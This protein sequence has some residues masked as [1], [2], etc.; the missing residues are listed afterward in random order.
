MLYQF[1]TANR[2]ELIKRCQ[3]KTARRSMPFMPPALVNHGVPLFLKQLV[4]VLHGEHLTTEREHSDTEPTPAHTDIGKAAALH[5]AEMLRLGHSIDQ[6]VHEYGDVCQTVTDLAVE[7]KVAISIDEFRTLNRCLD[8]AIADAVASYAEARR[9]IVGRAAEST[10]VDMQRLLDEH[11][12]LVGV[13]LHAFGAIRTGNVGLRGPTGNLLHPFLED[14]RTL[15][16]RTLGGN[17]PVP[18]ET[19]RPVVR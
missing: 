5:G 16:Q 3:E 19:Q 11:A 9:L 10:A 13:A 7:K 15:P 1:L 2:S 6:V 8:N 17:A 12:R 14:L 4:E 18:T